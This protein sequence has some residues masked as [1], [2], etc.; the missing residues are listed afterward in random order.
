[1]ASSTIRVSAPRVASYIREYDVI[2]EV[3]NRYTEGV[4][5]GESS[6]MKSVFHENATFFGFYEGK[7]LAGSIQILFDWVDGNG[8]VPE[9]QVR[10]AGVD[11]LETIAVV[12]LEM[13]NV[14][15]KLA[16]QSG[17]RLSDLFQLIK[18]DGKWNISQKSFH[19]HIAP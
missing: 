6:I 17:A 3:I 15:G 14:T 11:I 18:A 16:G 13:E 12:R 8:P 4:R 5:T 2:T 1:M 10:M 19:W 7:L 9:M